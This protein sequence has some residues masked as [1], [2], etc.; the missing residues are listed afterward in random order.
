MTRADLAAE[1]GKSLDA[2]LRAAYDLTREDGP[3]Y[4]TYDQLAEAWATTRGTIAGLVRDWRAQNDRAQVGEE[5]GP[6]AATGEDT[7]LQ[8][9]GVHILSQ[10]DAGESSGETTSERV[11]HEANDDPP[12]REAERRPPA[13]RV[14]MRAAVYDIETTD[15]GTEG[16][17]GHLVTCCILPLESE[18]VITL[19][20]TFDEHENDLRLLREVAAALNS[21]DILIGHNIQ[22]FDA[23][24]LNSRLMY[25]RLAV[26]NTSLVFDTY[27]VAKSLAIRTRKGLGNLL[28]YFGLE[29]VKTTIYRTSW[30]NIRSPYRGEFEHTLAEIEYHCQQD[31]IGNRNLFDVLYPYALSMRA[32]P[33]KLSKMMSW[34]SQE[35]NQ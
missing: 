16:Y 10:N 6:R 19:S 12:Q 29:G 24:W 21:Y 32:N 35:A 13:S 2:L 4:H 7:P 8:G 20:I 1:L 27:Q 3:D 31:V 5:C 15:F 14:M 30:N 9:F 33:F 26:L 22:A 25:H 11:E 28:D 17:A 18:D 34:Q 23:N